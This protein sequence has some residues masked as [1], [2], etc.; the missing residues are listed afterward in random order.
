[1]SASPGDPRMSKIAAQPYCLSGV[2]TFIVNHEGI[3]YSR[4]LGP[5]TSA[6]ARSMPLFDPE[7]GWRPEAGA[8][9]RSE[10]GERLPRLA[11]ERGCT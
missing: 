9:A 2:R 10:E 6:V 4:D 11:S 8:I 1:M 3:A 7:G 5:R